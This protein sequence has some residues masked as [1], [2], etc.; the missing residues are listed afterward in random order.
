[1][2]NQILYVRDILES[3]YL[4][5][6]FVEGMDY[7]EFLDDP[8]TQSAVIR[9]FEIIGEAVKKLDTSITN[10][11]PEIDWSAVAGMRDLLIH[12]YFGVDLEIVWQSLLVDLPRFKET[13]RAIEKELS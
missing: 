2:R 12:H 11:Y 5:E 9:Q 13:M 4:I 6:S 10:N 3:V 1:M 8:K 7:N